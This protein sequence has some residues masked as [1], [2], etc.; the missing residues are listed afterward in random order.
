[1]QLGNYALLFRATWTPYDVR[2]YT[3]SIY[4]ADKIAITDLQG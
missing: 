4:A 1:L 3:F 2:D